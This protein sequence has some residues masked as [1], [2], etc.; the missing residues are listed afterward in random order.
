[1]ADE[2]LSNIP[3]TDAWYP[4][5]LE[6]RINWRTRV[7]TP[8]QVRQFGDEAI[9]MIDRMTI[10]GPTLP[11]FGMRT[12]AGFAAQRPGVVVESVSNYIRLAGGMA[13]AQVIT[14]DS[15]RQDAKALADILNDAQKM[16]G[17]DAARIA[18]VRAEISRIVSAG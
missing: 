17:A 5:A 13:R 7:T 2:R 3:W 6:L 10:M 8:Q 11:L 14:F 1:M 18:E 12:R 9:P 4:E 15:L 16:P